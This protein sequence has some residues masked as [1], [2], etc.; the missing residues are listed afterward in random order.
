[1]FSDQINAHQATPASLYSICGERKYLN[2]HERQEFIAAVQ[3]QPQSIRLLC[4]LL[5]FSGC[6]LTEALNLT[7]EHILASEKAVLI[8]SLKKRGMISYRH[9][10]IPNDLVTELAH[11]SE[12]QPKRLFP[13]RRTRALHYVKQVLQQA[14]IHG[15][16]GTARGLRHTFATYVIQCGVPITVLQRWLGHASIKT[17]AIY[18]QVLGAEERKVAARMW[19]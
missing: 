13:W 12:Q 18:T 19:R 14:G 3:K 8:R 1:M 7:H 16:R 11:L 9:I 17:T 4:L 15:I 6:R 2:Q 10:P 5:A